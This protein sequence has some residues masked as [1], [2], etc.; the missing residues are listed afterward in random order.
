MSTF[1]Q[2]HENAIFQENNCSFIILADFKLYNLHSL[3]N[4]GPGAGCAAVCV[5]GPSQERL[6]DGTML[7]IAS[8]IST[9]K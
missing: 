9:L 5:S 4:A 3:I 7:L 6:S 8:T 1:N 2:K